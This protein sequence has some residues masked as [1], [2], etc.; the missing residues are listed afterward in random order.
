MNESELISHA[1]EV[2]VRVYPTSVYY[3]GVTQAQIPMVLL[4]YGGVSEREMQIGIHL[5]QTA[6]ELI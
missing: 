6:W 5:L 1:E 3:D 2:G 4:G